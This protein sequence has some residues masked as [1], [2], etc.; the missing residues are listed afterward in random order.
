MSYL[1]MR[2]FITLFLFFQFANV[3]AQDRSASLF[4]HFDKNVYANNEMVYF[5]GYV[6]KL[7]S[8][9][10]TKHSVL[11][12]ALIRDADSTVII[13]DKFF[14]QNGLAFGNMMILNKMLPGNYHFVASTN[15]ILNGW[16][17]LLFK[18]SVVIKTAL[19]P[20]FNANIKLLNGTSTEL[21]KKVMISISSFEGR[22]LTKPIAITYQYG[23]LK[24]KTVADQSGQLLLT[25]P[26]QE[27]VINP[28]LN[29]KIKYENDSSFMSIA[30]PRIKNKA[31]VKF[32]PEGG[33]MVANV[34]STLA[35][36]IKDQ[37]RLP[38]SAK[39]LLFKNNQ[40]ID[41][42]ETNLYGIGK[43]SLVPDTNAVYTVKLIHS[44]LVDSG[45][46]LPKPVNSGVVL[47]I[48]NAVVSDTLKLVLR[49]KTPQKVIISVRD[50]QSIY[51]SQAFNLERD[52]QRMKIPLH[53]MP[54]GLLSLTISDDQQRPLAERLFFAH[55]D[56]E[57]QLDISSDKTSYTVR[58]KVTLRVKLRSIQD[59]ALV[60]IASVQ[61]T[62]LSPSRMQDISN[63]TYLTHELNQLPVQ[64]NGNSLADRDYME[65]VLLVKG[66]RR[67]NWKDVENKTDSLKYVGRLTY[68]KKNVK[69]NY[70]IGFGTP[71]AMMLFTDSL[72]YFDIP[73]HHLVQKYGTRLF[74]LLNNLERAKL[75]DD[76]LIAI[77][78]P[79]QVMNNKIAKQLNTETPIIPSKL[80][81]NKQFILKNSER[82]ILLKEVVISP[83][84]NDFKGNEC[85]DYVCPFNILNCINHVGFIGNTLP[86]IGREYIKYSGMQGRIEYKG[87]FVPNESV[88]FQVKPIYLNR[89]Y[90][91]SD[92]QDPQEPAFFSTIYWN[93]GT[94]INGKKATEIS[95]YTSDIAGKFRVVIQGVSNRNVVYA[96]HF[97]EVKE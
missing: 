93:Y 75:N 3:C 47:N 94:L 58:E 36:E 82:A 14:L 88:F 84:R 81:D 4:V 39:G 2:N 72:G 57:K 9:A 12:V 89:E 67:Y 64:L 54:K 51:L 96:E 73:Y 63:F 29:V 10:M 15:R 92:Y 85:G 49:T 83:Q 43:F 65:R 87:C 5:T 70:V 35:W 6:L 28:N 45:Y 56:P 71:S 74:L 48:P 59:S 42:I 78:D 86:F 46:Q 52:E 19:D 97:F 37:Q 21:Q 22:F 13:Q 90:Y 80:L 79:Y 32:Y 95:F 55:Y 69:V 40:I 30:I 77:D 53:E 62:R 66:W 18:Q 23:N 68:P 61:D 76:Y 60:S 7:D 16:P 41:T 11:S 33:N 31:N 20:P 27:D 26:D 25:L 8:V 38:L 50:Q 1:I 24:K 17:E 34:L 91:E 44:A